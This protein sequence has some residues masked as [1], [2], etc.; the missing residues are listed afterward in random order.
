MCDHVKC[1]H[2]SAHCHCCHCHLRHRGRRHHCWCHCWWTGYLLWW[3]SYVHHPA[4]VLQRMT[5]SAQDYHCLWW[6]L[7]HH[8]H[9]GIVL[10]SATIDVS[11]SLARHTLRQ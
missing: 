2:T 1:V 11:Y 3:W 9:L 10:V 5:L 7:L 4:A 8:C 6:H